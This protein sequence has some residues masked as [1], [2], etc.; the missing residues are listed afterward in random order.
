MVRA[1]GVSVL[2]MSRS[3][4]DLAAGEWA[5]LAVLAERPAHGFA[6]A[7]AM[8]P[9]G[10]IGKV[11]SLRRPLVYRAINVLCDAGLARSTG[12]VASR[13]GPRRTVL[14]V[15]PAGRAALRRWLWNPVDHVRDARSLLLLKLLFITRS[16]RDPRQLLSGQRGRFEA[17]AQRLTVAAETAEGFDAVLVRWRLEST[18]AAIRFLDGLLGA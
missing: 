18:T 5:V 10:E 12:T 1:P 14:E 2:T 16:G 4:E 13:S 3:T 7:R 11:W 8:A 17:L 9:D 6:V 15:T